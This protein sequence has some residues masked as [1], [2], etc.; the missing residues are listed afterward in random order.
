MSDPNRERFEFMLSRLAYDFRSA[1]ESETLAKAI[2]SDRDIL[3]GRIK[4][5]EEQA[6]QLKTLLRAVMEEWVNGRQVKE[7]MGL[8]LRKKIEAVY[9]MGWG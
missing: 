2:L 6:A 5:L 3:V 7:G 8:S 9:V 4:D 1:T